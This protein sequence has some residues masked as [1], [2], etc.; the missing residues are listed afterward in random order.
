MCGVGSA[1]GEAGWAGATHS[2]L[3]GSAGDVVQ[4]RD[5]HGGIHFH[6]SAEL[7]R[8]T[9]RQLPGDVRVF[10][11]R[12]HDLGRLDALALGGELGPAAS[13]LVVAGTAGV[14]KT[15]LAVR[16]A[17]RHRAAFPGG[18]LYVN[19]RGY[20][21]GA[22]VSP[23]DAL[24]RFLLALG[25]EPA[26]VPAELEDRAAFYRS[27]LA[28]R[29]MLVV[30]DNAATVG[31]VRPLL[32]GSE[33]CL[34]L[35]TSRGRLSGLVARDGAHRVTLQVL[36]ESEAVALLRATTEGYRAGD[37]DEQVAELARLC[38]RLPL[39]L[40]IAAERAAARPRMP[41]SALIRDLRDESSLWDALSSEDEE[42]A[43]AVRSVFAWSYRALPAAA[44]RLFRLLGLHP[45]AEFSTGAAAALADLPE[46]ETARLL[47]VLAGAYL[48][49][50]P[51]PER[52]GFHDLLRAYAA[53][54][55]AHQEDPPQARAALERMCS[56]YLHTLHAAVEACNIV[57]DPGLTLVGDRPPTVLV[58]PTANAAL[59]WIAAEA[60]NLLAIGRAATD[61]GQDAAA[62]QVLT[63]LRVAYY[64]RRPIGSWL[65]PGGWALEAARRSGD[66]GGQIAALVGLGIN[67]RLVHDLERSLTF[68][69]QAL[70][71]PIDDPQVDA[72][73]LNAYGLA[74]LRARRLEEARV[75]FE[76]VSAAARDAADSFRLLIALLN[77]AGTTLAAGRHQQARA[78]LDHA[79][80]QMPPQFPGLERAD[81]L[82]RWATLERECGQL[83]K[84]HT[85]V[86]QALALAREHSAT[87]Y[88]G[89]LETELG[90]I[91]IAEGAPAAALETL[92]HAASVQRT[93]ADRSREALTFD[94]TGQAYQALG[95][96]DQAAPMHR[97]AATAHRDLRDDW[98]QA[99]ALT[100]L[101][102]TLDALG[103]YN[104]ARQ[105][106]T[107]ALS[108]IAVY[109]DPRAAQLRQHL[110]EAAHNRGA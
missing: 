26:A 45:G 91:Q 95:R 62:W 24:E 8:L 39:A 102:D 5:V 97:L 27:L 87:T 88:E 106:R 65:E 101:A 53:D 58:F 82:A 100:H 41:L 85:A 38:A 74:L 57:P 40:R 50:Q 69:R 96:P 93:L 47:D 66:A 6:A 61:T 16:W 90:L 28:E 51:G 105:T 48:L 22:P 64:D 9:P 43:D 20:D 35:V 49:E 83:D 54:Q 1:G 110:T 98:N 18:Q 11:N 71:V 32:P 13:V 23:M 59:E 76:Q 52:Y 86:E 30:L 75:A 44:A 15:A 14:G 55:A 94:A 46:P 108:L 3:S 25:V 80:A 12:V 33:G 73:R 109:D 4:A 84:A 72:Y 56:W 104:P 89:F 19:L 107:E 10:V 78:H 37:Q 7:A 34:V 68:H 31:Q 29:R 67:H 60:D 21:P 17:H 36:P 2:Q 63:L 77:L 99:L 81:A 92:A 42:E 79:F 103:E 70:G